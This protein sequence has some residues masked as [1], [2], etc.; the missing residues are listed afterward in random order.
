MNRGPQHGA[1][2]AQ[3]GERALWAAVLAAAWKDLDREIQKALKYQKNRKNESPQHLDLR[4]FLEPTPYLRAVMVAVDLDP[5]AVREEAWRMV[6]DSL[7][8]W[9]KSGRHSDLI[10][11]AS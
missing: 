5:E 1:E 8:A 7:R 11:G 10:G 4:V 3:S 6:P 2:P 9:A